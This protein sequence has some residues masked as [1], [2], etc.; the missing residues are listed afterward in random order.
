MLAEL[1]QMQLMLVWPLTRTY[2]QT[3]AQ[4]LG[5]PAHAAPPESNIGQ[6]VE[7]ATSTTS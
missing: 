5:V 7:T 3:R 6:E 2:M 4:A 1:Q